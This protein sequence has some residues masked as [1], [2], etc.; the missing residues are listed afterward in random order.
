[1]ATGLKALKESI[2][3]SKARAAGGGSPNGALKYYTWKNDG[4]K[5]LIRFLTDDVITTDFYE[6]VVGKDGKAT[7]DFIK[8]ETGEDWVQ[9]Y[10]GQ[11]RDYKTKTLGP[12][13]A[14]ELTVGMA[15]MREEYSKDGKQAIR[16]KIEKVEVD[17]T[18]YDARY[19][20]IVKQSHRNFW[21]NVM[22]YYNRFGTICDRDFEVTRNGAGKDTDY[23]FFALD[24]VPD[25][26]NEEAVQK[27]YGYGVKVEADDPKRFLYVPETL[28][29]WADRY[30]SEDRAKYWLEGAVTTHD[31]YAGEEPEP[32][33]KADTTGEYDDLRASLLN[34]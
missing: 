29:Q 14:R 30:S 27:A 20:G 8:N 4:D 3:R 15:V 33:I 19:F 6:W 17:G 28:S 24:P 7:R 2:D 5:F 10:N 1:M 21:K 32:D 22:V 26:A 16:D 31:H 9:K 25:L 18:E 12:A 34:T 23:S 11:S 13:R